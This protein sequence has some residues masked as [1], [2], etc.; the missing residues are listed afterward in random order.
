MT[1]YQ[2]IIF[3]NH[4]I[5]KS[6]RNRTMCIK[7]CNMTKKWEF[8]SSGEYSKTDRLKLNIQCGKVYKDVYLNKNEFKLIPFKSERTPNN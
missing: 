8:A 2:I 1:N 3:D 4:N 6:F 5:P 7:K